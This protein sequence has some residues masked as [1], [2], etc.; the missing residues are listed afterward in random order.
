MKGSEASL[1]LTCVFQPWFQR[2][3]WVYHCRLAGTANSK[4]DRIVKFD[5][6]VTVMKAND[7]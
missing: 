2:A 5:M 4:Y 3:Q 1:E 6:K 7:D